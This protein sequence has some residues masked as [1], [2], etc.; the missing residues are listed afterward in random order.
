MGIFD[1]CQGCERV[2]RIED[3]LKRS[4]NSSVQ[5]M[6]EEK[7]PD[8]AHSIENLMQIKKIKSSIYRDGL[9]QVLSQIHSYE[10]LFE[11]VDCIRREA[12]DSENEK[13]EILLQE[14]W[15]LL[16][17]ERQLSARISKDWTDIGFQGDDPKTDFRGMGILGLANLVYFAKRHNN[18]AIS[19]LQHSHHPQYGYSYAIVGIN[20]T[21]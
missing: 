11:L 8:V 20:I 17:P 19:T 16:Q 9:V 3:S 21:S 5:T 2:L 6:L 15:R 12:Y 13:H 4:K 10:T 14:L 1:R 18:Q 7:S